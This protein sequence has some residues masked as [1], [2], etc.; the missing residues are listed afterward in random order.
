VLREVGI[1]PGRQSSKTIESLGDRV[2]DVVVTVCDG[3]RE[4][5]PYVPGRLRTIHYAFRDP[6]AVDGTPTERADAFREV[7]DEIAVWLDAEFGGAPHPP[8]EDEWPDVLERIEASGLPTRD[9]TAAH[10]EHVLVVREG[11]RVVGSVAVEAHGADGLLRSL[12]VAPEVRGRGLG[13]RLVEAAETAAR[14]RGLRSLTLLT[15]TA[16][17]FF[18]ARGY[19]LQDRAEAPEAVRQSSEFTGTCPSSA[20]CLGKSLSP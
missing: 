9:L 15:T 6:S 4:A 16:A 18:E 10:R 17:P 5:C 12:A 14:S 19:A 13:S 8:S 2:F 3:A 7:R 20:V 11:G 1:D